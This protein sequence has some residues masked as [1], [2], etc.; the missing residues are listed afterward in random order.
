MKRNSTYIMQEKAFRML[1]IS[2]LCNYK[3][4]NLEIDTLYFNF[5]MKAKIKF[6]ARAISAELCENSINTMSQSFF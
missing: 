1:Q 6:L 3:R 4:Q 2:L 5:H